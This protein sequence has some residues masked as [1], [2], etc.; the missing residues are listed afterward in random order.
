M[1][2]PSWIAALVAAVACSSADEPTVPR[3][4]SL[5][6]ERV[7]D[8]RMG[9]VWM[10]RDS[11]RELSWPEA[12]RHCRELAPGSNGSGWRLPSIEELAALYDESTQQPC[13]EAVICRID[14][15]IR[16]SSP[17][18]WSASAPQPDRRLYYDFSF[19]T[20]LAPLIRPSLTRRALCTRDSAR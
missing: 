2:A 15:A 5:E 1:R 20:Q 13:G 12:D 17:Y 4:G 7:R 11:D 14:P 3:F 19:G 9:L 10:V 8:A 18:Q 16:L 6:A